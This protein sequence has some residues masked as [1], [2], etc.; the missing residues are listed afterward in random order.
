[1]VARDQHAAGAE[2]LDALVIA[3][4]G[5]EAR[6]DMHQGSARHGQHHHGGVRVAVRVGLLIEHHRGLGEDLDR[7]FLG[8]PAG[9]VEVVD[10]RVVEDPVGHLS[11]IV[12]RR[13]LRIAAGDDRHLEPPDFAGGDGIAECPVARIEAPVE[14]DRE[15]HLGLR[16]DAGSAV[17]LGEVEID[18]LL[19]E[20]RLAGAGRAA[21]QLGMGMGGGADHHRAQLTVGQCLLQA[22]DR[23]AMLVGQHIG[24]DRIE[25]D[26]VFEP[27]LGMG[28]DVAGMDLSDEAGADEAEIDH[29]RLRI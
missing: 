6:V 25:I 22:D 20:D 1:M 2:R 17:D 18:R 7:I 8:E 3:I 19:A 24:G 26:H 23:R 21:D 9:D 15:G 29:A 10:H 4:D 12:R 27:R 14:A 16:Q 11:H 13:D 28:R 5:A